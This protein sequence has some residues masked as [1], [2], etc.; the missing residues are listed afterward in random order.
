VPPSFSILLWTVFFTSKTEIYNATSLRSQVNRITIFYVIIPT[1]VRLFVWTR[2]AIFSN[3]RKTGS[4]LMSG[5][6]NFGKYFNLKN[7][8][9]LFGVGR[10]ESWISVQHLF[11]HDPY[12]PNIIRFIKPGRWAGHV[13]RMGETGDAGRDLVE[14]YGGKITLW[15]PS[16]RWEDNIKIYQHEIGL[17]CG[18]DWSGSGSV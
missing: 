14:K 15:E 4:L 8:V 18:L 2:N 11:L 7:E 10:A 5:N 13:T 6:K 12:S 1:F 3:F 16:H 9:R 17:R